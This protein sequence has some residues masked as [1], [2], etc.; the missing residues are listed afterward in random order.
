MKNKF[1][2]NHGGRDQYVEI[3]HRKDLVNDCSIRATAIFLDL[4]Y[5]EVRDDLFEIAKE[6]FN[7][8]N[9]DA[10]V[11]EYLER[12]GFKW[13]STIYK[14]GKKK[15]RVGEFPVNTGRVMIR[16]SKHWTTIVDQVVHDTWDC[17][18]Y[19]AGRYLTRN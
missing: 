14:S 9:A 13:N 2:K 8:P 3:K 18:N 7:M 11:Y 4:P 16:V 19:A 15:F 6:R 12:K 5:H 1:Q 17:R 10:V